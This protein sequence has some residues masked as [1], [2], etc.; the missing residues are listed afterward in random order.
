MFNLEKSISCG[1]AAMGVF[2]VLTGIWF[3]IMSEVPVAEQL[4]GSVWLLLAGAYTVTLPYLNRST[5]P[6]LRGWA[7]RKAIAIGCN[8]FV[9]VWIAL[10]L[11]DCGNIIHFSLGTMILPNVIC[12]PL[13]VAGWATVLV[14]AHGTNAGS[15][16]FW[17]PAVQE[18]LGMAHQEALRL[19]HNFVG[20][21]HILLGLLESK[22]GVVSK[23]LGGIGV[24]REVVRAE[25]ESI[26][27]SGPQWQSRGLPAY[28]PRAKRACCLAFQEAR[29]LE[30]DRVEPLHL[31]LG[32]L[33]E[34]S[35]VAA[36]VLKKLGV[37]LERARAEVLKA[38]T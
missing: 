8:F 22:E 10:L 21:E 3:L 17:S 25:I 11:L 38:A 18:C 31:L 12:W 19:N 5:F 24:R 4:F 6:G 15:L 9:I 14:L 7:L 13:F 16:G 30:R 20:T 2:I 28:T 23:V 37:D 32:L 29:S 26:V 33:R 35:G 36:V 1:C 27:A 34:G